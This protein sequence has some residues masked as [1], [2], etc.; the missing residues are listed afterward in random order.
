MPL[1]LYSCC[2]Y[3]TAYYVLVP[4]VT[5]RREVVYQVLLLLITEIYYGYIPSF[6]LYTVLIQRH[7]RH[8]VIPYIL[9]SRF[10][11]DASFNYPFRSHHQPTCVMS[12]E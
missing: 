5:V 7:P 6:I 10:K 12:D 4:V 3:L 11:L 9:A 1:Y 2:I 8:V